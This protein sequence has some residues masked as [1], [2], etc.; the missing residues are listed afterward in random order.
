[1]QNRAHINPCGE[2]TKRIFQIHCSHLG[3]IDH[4]KEQLLWE[5]FIS[6]DFHHLL[7]HEVGKI[8][9]G[10]IGSR[11]EAVNDS[12][13]DVTKKWKGGRQDLNKDPLPLGYHHIH[14]IGQFLQ[15]VP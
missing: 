1:M 15:E 7:Q 13:K 2:E 14:I 9:H 6:H 3:F 11:M 4:S 10:S 12:G 8:K 5:N